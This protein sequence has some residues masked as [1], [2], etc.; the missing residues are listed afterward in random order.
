MRTGT[1]TSYSDFIEGDKVRG[2]WVYTRFKINSGINKIYKILSASF[3]FLM[4]NYT[5]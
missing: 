1:G 3:D 2:Y 4:S 5:R